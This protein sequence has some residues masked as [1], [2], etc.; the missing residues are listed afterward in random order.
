MIEEKDIKPIPKYILKLIKNIDNGSISKDSGYTRF[1]AYFTKIKKILCKIIVAVKSRYKKIYTKQ[2]AVHAIGYEDCFVKDICYYTLAGYVVGWHEEGLTKKPKWFETSHW[3]TADDKY[4]NPASIL[5]NPEYALKFDKYKYSAVDNYTG[6]DAFKYLQ[7]YEK[8]PIAEMLVK[9]G[10]SRLTTSKL[11]L[12][13]LTKNKTFR[14]WI[15]NNSNKLQNQWYDITVILKAFKEKQELTKTQLFADFQKQ[16]IKMQDNDLI[17]QIIDKSEMQKFVN[18]LHNQGIDLNTYRDYLVACNYLELD[19][20]QDRN[21]YPKNFKKWHDIRIDQYNTQKALLDK[22]ERKELYEE[23]EKIANKYLSMQRMM[24]EDY[25]VI[26]AKSPAELI[27]EGN[28]LHHCVGRM[29]YDQKFIREESLIFFV[30]N[31][32]NPETPLV[33]L[34]YSLENKKVLQCYGDNDSKPSEEILDY[35]NNIWLPYASRKLRKIA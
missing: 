11:I 31:K 30:R 20:T 24:D 16:Y 8:Y 25:V 14:K 17:M 10:L 18:Y 26:L 3:C 22:E 21:K 12:K 35:V 9:I 15:Y 34:E 2:V 7:I 6:E 4:F 1:Y 13:E 19:M 27:K 29:N 33:T 5:V 32:L 23:F 28:K